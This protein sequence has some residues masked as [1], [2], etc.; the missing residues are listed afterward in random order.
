MRITEDV[1][2][3]NILNVFER[4]ECSYF[5]DN[6]MFLVNVVDRNVVSSYEQFTNEFTLNLN[7]KFI[8]ITITPNNPIKG[9]IIN[10]SSILTTEFGAV[11]PNRTVSC[12]YNKETSWF[13][14]DSDLTNDLGYISFLIDTLNLEFEEDD[15][16]VRFYLAYYLKQNQKDYSQS[17]K[18]RCLKLLLFIKKIGIYFG[19]EVI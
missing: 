6:T 1:S 10:I 3:R 18:N 7:S 11:L 9:Q 13:E 5:P 4:D 16:L 12:H 19:L 2:A 8:N 15:L 17:K 14:I